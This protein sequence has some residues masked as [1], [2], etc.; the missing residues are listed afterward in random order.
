MALSL[1]TLTGGMTPHG[2]QLPH[3]TGPAAQLGSFHPLAWKNPSEVKKPLARAF[4]QMTK[5]RRGRAWSKALGW[6]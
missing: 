4:S 5:R 1:S 6:L 2:P 3:D